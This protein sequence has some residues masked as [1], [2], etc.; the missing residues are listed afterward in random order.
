V[1][2]CWATEEDDGTEEPRWGRVGRQRSR[3]PAR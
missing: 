2:H 1:L 3:T